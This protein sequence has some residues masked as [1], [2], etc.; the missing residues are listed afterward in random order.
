MK[1]ELY[2]LKY[3]FSCA[4]VLVQNKTITEEKYQEIRT[5]AIN[6]KIMSKEELSKIFPAAMRRLSEVAEKMKKDIWNIEV[7]RKYFLEEHNDYIDKGDGMYGVFPKS[8]CESCKVKT[9]IILKKEE[10]TYKVKINNEERKVLSELF[11]NANVGDK[12]AIH[13]GYAMEKIN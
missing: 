11:P 10:S 1:P 2:F 13:K 4:E 8:F 9:G 7:L 6:N 5:N 3:A 12:I